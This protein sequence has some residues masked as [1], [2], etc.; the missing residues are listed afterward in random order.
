MIRV[1]IYSILLIIG[2]VFS[3]SFDLHAISEEIFLITMLCL[4]YIMIEVGL[5][6]TLEKDNLKSYGV[7]YLVAM[8][9]AT[10]PWVLCAIYFSYTMGLNWQ[11]ALLVGRFS[12]PTSAGVL[13]T[14]LGAVGLGL[15]WVYKKTRILAI[16]DDLDTILLMIPLKIMFV[17]FSIKALILVAL[18]IAILLSAYHWLDQARF[19]TGRHWIFLYA[20]AIVGFCVWMDHTTDI[21]IEILLPSFAFGCLMTRE[22]RKEGATYEEHLPWLDFGMRALFMFLVGL[23]LPRIEFFG[24]SSQEIALHVF[25]LTILSNL[26][27]MFPIFFYKKEASLNERLALCVS[28][29]PRGEVGAAVLFLAMGLGVNGM[30]VEIAAL[31]L[32][33]NLL[34]TAPFILLV[35]W[36]L[37]PVS[38]TN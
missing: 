33:L 18:I 2:I 30:A 8:G 20:A 13:F 10:F 17:G 32:V 35:I 5:E 26:G 31:S 28:M 3:Q 6:F 4:S 21:E 37:K 9:A 22:R 19:P 1:A 14:M 38:R 15:T 16:F 12:A 23:S 7:D 36:L 25:V 27:K 11:E 24:I 29:F 34:F